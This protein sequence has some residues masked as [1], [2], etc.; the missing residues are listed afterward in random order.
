MKENPADKL[1]R[2]RLEPGHIS[3]EGFLGTDKRPIA[4]IIAADTGAVEAEG[5][6]VELLGDFLENLHQIADAG[7]EGRVPAYEGNVTVRADETLGQ[8]PCPFACGS[9]CHKAEVV[10][11]DPDGNDLLRFSPLDA[12]LISEH[13]FFEGNGSPHR[14]EPKQLIEL[15]RHCVG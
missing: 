11:K 9:S 13:G 15:Y 7:W 12:H 8:I 1:I 10:V 14:I 4:D 3:V 2:D 6:T 5:L